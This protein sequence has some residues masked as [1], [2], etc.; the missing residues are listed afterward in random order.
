MQQ[1][2]IKMRASQW[3]E[4]SQKNKHISGAERIIERE[5]VNLCVSH[6]IDRALNHSKGKPDF[7]N[8]KIEEVAEKNLFRLPALPVTELDTQSPEE[9]RQAIIGFLDEMGLKNSQKIM[10]MMNV[11]YDL[12][13]AVLLNVDTLERLEENPERGIR[14]T[15]MDAAQSGQNEK[16]IS[17][18]NHY[19]EAIVLATKVAN[20]PHIIWEICISDDPDYITGYF[21]SKEKGYVRISNIKEMGSPKGGRIFLFKGTEDEVQETV[22]FLQK[23]HV[24]VEKIDTDVTPKEPETV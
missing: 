17:C 12:R 3:D 24:I 13:G 10:D 14:A 1:Y 15:Y 8:I 4:E 11:A 18:K 21:S 20:A 23:K 6:L 16:N 2:S 5:D 22:D 19:M 7:I 9:G